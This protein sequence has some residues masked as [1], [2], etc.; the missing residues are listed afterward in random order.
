MVAAA[1]SMA[2]S[3]VTLPTGS[4][5]PKSSATATLN[6]NDFLTLL[7]TQLEKQNP[8]NPTSPSDLAAELAQF[9]TATGVQNLN[10]T[11]QTTSGL[12]AASL[13]GH[14]VAVAGNALIL[15]QSGSAGG[16]FTLSAAAKD[17]TVAITDSTGKLVANLDLGAM[18]AGEQNFSWNGK[19]LDGSTAPAGMDV[20]IGRGASMA[21]GGA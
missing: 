20:G 19:A 7:T 12:Q 17:V 6:Q 5:T 2:A 11:I 13:I 16:A 10:M 14:N 21:G 1:S 9:S 15:G 18:P 4:Q 8:L 3:V